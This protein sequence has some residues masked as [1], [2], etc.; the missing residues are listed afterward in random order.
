MYKVVF[1]PHVH[2]DLDKLGHASEQK[3]LAAI[4]KKLTKDPVGYGDPLRKDLKGFYKLRVSDCRVI[5]K[6]IEDQV[7]VLVLGVGKRAEGDRENVYRVFTRKK[8][9]KRM[10]VAL[11]EL[12]K[13]VLHNVDDDDE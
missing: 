7:V 5:Y 6:V 8:L 11:A 12:R 2:D 1:S 3:I 9:D 13:K 4:K 10:A